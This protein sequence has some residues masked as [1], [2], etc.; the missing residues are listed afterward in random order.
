MVRTH[1]RSDT[2]EMPGGFVDA[3]ES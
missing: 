1:V 2:W 3:G